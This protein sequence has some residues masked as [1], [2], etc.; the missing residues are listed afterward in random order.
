MYNPILVEVE[1][2][3]GRERRTSDRIVEINKYI[4]ENQDKFDD[5][6]NLAI[7]DSRAVFGQRS[8]D[9]LIA[10]DEKTY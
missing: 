9:M 1:E 4:A 8:G 5:I 2:A 3:L 10:A 6:V 7:A